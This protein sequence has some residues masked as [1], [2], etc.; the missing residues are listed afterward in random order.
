MKRVT[1]QAVTSI[2]IALVT[3]TVTTAFT[4]Y[5]LER[6]W[7]IQIGAN[8]HQRIIYGAYNCANSE[9]YTHQ[10]KL[11]QHQTSDQDSSHWR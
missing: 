6:P 10:K 3:T 2:T 11:A 8:N 1:A 5:L 7:C 4:S 9:G